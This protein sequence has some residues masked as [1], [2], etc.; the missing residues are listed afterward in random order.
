MSTKRKQYARPPHNSTKIP[1]GYSRVGI[2][3]DIANAVRVGT[4]SPHEA[5]RFFAKLKDRG[6]TKLAEDAEI[7]ARIEQGVR[8]SYGVFSKEDEAEARAD[9]HR[10]FAR[11]GFWR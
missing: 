10:Y 6:F 9:T 4:V 5:D 1:D 7:I 2:A 8:K 3:S 11:R